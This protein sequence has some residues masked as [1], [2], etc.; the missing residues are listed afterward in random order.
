MLPTIHH[1]KFCQHLT[2]C[3]RSPC[4]GDSYKGEWLAERREDCS[5]RAHIERYASIA[6]AAILWVA[7]PRRDGQ[8]YACRYEDYVADLHKADGSLVRWTYLTTLSKR[9]LPCGEGVKKARRS[10]Q[11]PEITS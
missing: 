3:G 11:M 8:R 9:A 1:Y 5:H 4:S 10:P 7:Q 6:K 2:T